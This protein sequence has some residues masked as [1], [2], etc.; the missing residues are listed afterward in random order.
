MQFKKIN[1]SSFSVYFLFAA[2]CIITLVT[3]SCKKGVEE[4]PQLQQPQQSLVEKPENNEEKQALEIYRNLSGLVHEDNAHSSLFIKK[5]LED[6]ENF[7]LK[8]ENSHLLNYS[9]QV[10][11]DL[12]KSLRELSKSE[13]SLETF[14]NYI[15]VHPNSRIIDGLHF[16][17]GCYYFHRGNLQN[18]LKYFKIVKQKYSNSYFDKEYLIAEDISNL[19][20]NAEELKLIQNSYQKQSDE[21]LWKLGELYFHSMQRSWNTLEVGYDMSLPFSIF[22]ELIKKYPRSQWADN[23]EFLII[24]SNEVNAG[25]GGD[26][27][28]NLDYVKEYK[29]FIKKYPKSE[30]IPDALLSIGQLYFS[31]VRLSKEE[32]Y[33][34]ADLKM[35][36]LAKMKA[37]EVIAKYPLADAAKAAKDLLTEI[38]IFESKKK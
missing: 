2:C 6:Y 38:N 33:N 21:K 22:D 24:V 26:V 36:A 32:N 31:F 27:S 11:Y 34:Q 1:K 14:Q 8:Y 35:I 25:E 30:L 3:F 12:S 28:S 9:G 23:A 5:W 19:E 10:K 4:R 37:E 29:E 18:A 13:N 16:G 17:I 20:K 7:L 15:H